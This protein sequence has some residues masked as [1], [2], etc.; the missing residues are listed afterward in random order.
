VSGTKY[1]V[2]VPDT[3]G[4]EID[5]TRS[6]IRRYVTHILMNSFSILDI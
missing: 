5:R 3:N 2:L 1:G 4:T 6:A